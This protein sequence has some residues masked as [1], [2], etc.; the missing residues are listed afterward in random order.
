M[1]GRRYGVTLTAKELSANPDNIRHDLGPLG[2]LTVSIKHVGILEPLKVLPPTEGRGWMLLDGHRRFTA[3]QMAGVTKFSC[4]AFE[5]VTP[6]VQT[7]LMLMFDYQKKSLSY[8]ERAEAIGKMRDGGMTQKQISETIGMAQSTV[9]SYLALLDLDDVTLRRVEDGDVT[10]VEAVGIVRHVRRQ[11]NE[12]E[13]RLTRG[14]KPA[15]SA[16]KRSG[17]NSAWFNSSHRL[18][19]KV[20]DR[21]THADRPR[22]GLIGC[23][24]CWEETLL[25]EAVLDG[26][27]VD[28]RREAEAER[29]GS[30]E[31]D[32]AVVRRIL[33]GAYKTDANPAERR[34]VVRLWC[35][36][37]RTVNDL[38]RFT[39]W[40]TQRY[41]RP[42]VE[43]AR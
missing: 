42:R 16:Q 4:I 3:G 29:V 9:A 11:T 8:V 1:S 21:C 38:E 23:G 17:P 12:L 43:V 36:G 14:R 20:R 19:L 2:E 24:E 25:D 5:D 32:E 41:Y 34:E 28:E 13:G 6:A 26:R 15:T 7:Q 27:L 31:V 18:A 40:N 33:D 30:F 37:G 35:A 22:V 10:F 39:G